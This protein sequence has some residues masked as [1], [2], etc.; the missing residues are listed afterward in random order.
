M[1]EVKDIIHEKKKRVMTPAISGMTVKQERSCLSEIRSKSENITDTCLLKNGWTAGE[2]SLKYIM[3][4]QLK[5]KIK[6]S[7]D[8]RSNIKVNSI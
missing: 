8:K 2:F 4:H 5:R 6:T 1:S 7:S 3:G